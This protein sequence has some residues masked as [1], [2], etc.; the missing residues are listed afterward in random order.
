MG[1]LLVRGVILLIALGI[2][3]ILWKVR[4]A[5]AR[6]RLAELDAGTRCLSCGGTDVHPHGEGKKRCMDCGYVTDVAAMAAVRVSDDDIK[7][8]TR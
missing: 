7:N 6:T 4:Q 2:G 8:W 3:F 1:R 5:R